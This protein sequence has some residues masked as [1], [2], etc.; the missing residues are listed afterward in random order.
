LSWRLESDARRVRQ[1]AYRI[2][3]A[4][5]HVK[6]ASGLG[7]LWDSGKIQSGKSIGIF[8]QGKKLT[9]RQRCFWS[10]QVWDER[11]GASAPSVVSW[12]EMGLLDSQDWS[13]EWL[14]VENA[15]GRAD[16]EA[17]LHWIWGEPTREQTRRGF[18]FRFHV[19][20][21]AQNGQ[22]FASMNDYMQWAQI[23]RVWIDGAAVAGR[24]AW[25]DD[26]PWTEDLQIPLEQLQA[27]EHLVA[28]EVI[29]AVLPPNMPLEHG[30]TLF[31]RLNLES[32]ETLRVGAGLGWKTRLAPEDDWHVSGYD[33]RAWEAARPVSLPLQ[34]W[35]GQPAMYLRCPFL[36]DRPVVR[37]RLYATALG[38]YE[39][40][41]NGRRV[42]D[43]LLTP[44]PSDYAKRLLYQVHDVTDGV[45]VG[46]N[47]IA[48][49][50]GDGW[51]G[52]FDR[53]YPWGRP[54]R[55]VLAQL[56]LDF[57]DGSRQV[58]QTGPGWRTM[59]SP[60]QK[61]Q[62]RVGEIYDAR[63]EQPGWDTPT[64]D[65]SR[66]LV[67]QP[68]EEPGCRLV[69]Q[70]TPPIRATEVLE[71][72][73]IYQPKPGVYV[74]DFGQ[75][76][77]GWCRLRVKGAQ[78][79]RVELRF[80][81]LLA[82]S[83]EVEQPFMNIGEPKIDV[84][85]LRG[86]VGGETFEPHFTYR[87]FRYVQAEGLPAAPTKQTLEGVVVHTD[88]K[89]TGHLRASAPLI[90]RIWQACVWTRRSNFVGIP[91]DC[92]GREQRGY[93]DPAGICW[94]DAS[95]NMDVCALTARTME[96]IVDQQAADGAF[97]HVAPMPRWI[98]AVDHVPGSNPGYA[99]AGVILPWTAWQ[100]YGDLEFVERNWEAMNR[101]LQFI[102]D[103][104][105]DYLGRN[106]HALDYG[107][108][109]ALNEIEANSAVPATPKD[110]IGTAYW[111]HSAEL[112][113]QMARAI[114]RCDD[115][116]RLH[117]ISDRV[118]RA[119]NEAFVEPDSKIG[120]DSQ[121]G[122]I[123]ALKFGLL[124]EEKRRAGA[125]HLA[126]DIRKRNVSLTTG[127]L[128]TQFVLDVL[129][130][131]GFVDL[132]YDLLLRTECPSWG[133]MLQHG[134]M[135]IWETWSGKQEWRA[136]DG[137]IKSDEM[138]RNHSDLASISG[139]LFR[140]VA[141][142]DAATPGFE[143]IVIRPVLDSRVKR[144]GGDYDSIMG[145]ISTDWA[146]HADG[147]FSLS[148]SIPANTSARIHLPARLGA[149]IQEGRRDISQSGDVRLIH[150]SHHQAI[151]AVGS[152]A[153]R[154]RVADF[155]NPASDSAGMGMGGSGDVLALQTH[156]F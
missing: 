21:A 98:N 127:I 111:A 43:A 16:R 117:A 78:G 155:A 31:I 101:Y 144:G 95:F 89:M 82:P 128:G 76:F 139:F 80:A 96:N 129:V 5:S 116:D 37:A 114:G 54:P 84:Y 17:G 20:T 15:V 154:F 137:K 143:T 150:H 152:G 51:Y 14:A 94:D 49:I 24:G 55:R 58:I 18:R 71:P 156:E 92:T 56:E 142:I 33:D 36:I 9:S 72:R 35:P 153:Y 93:L 100:R 132:A 125:R 40:R 12:W 38:A 27:G 77:A 73:V 1:I 147:E 70:T 130:D 10:V 151:I 79:T 103:H 141:G 3:V 60:I 65:D 46:R 113:A 112:L 104:N 61:S 85:I 106:G 83:G 74:F 68:A 25:S 120:S 39:A 7:D 6:L 53:G 126:A 108:W 136:P 133:Y 119:F 42:S 115:A 75:N 118:R 123:L 62:V 32:G 81:E 41:L 52:H 138:A 64:F 30:L 105:P 13:A 110:L 28:V 145:R 59:D 86:E 131:A 48:L 23:T 124:P 88:L 87:G 91:T 146:Q 149:R 2:R 47:V 63:C 121:T 97:P 4:S 44:E 8:Y 22:L 67:A 102:L 134:G 50:V 57:A 69:A 90:E 148:V 122:Y 135:T 140:R 107:D 26:A 29:T 11:G 99:D 34:P 66:W 109:L 45:Q 19:P